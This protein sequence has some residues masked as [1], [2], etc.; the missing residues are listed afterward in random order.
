MDNNMKPVKNAAVP[1]QSETFVLRIST[2]NRYTPD[3]YVLLRAALLDWY[4]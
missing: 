4:R 1:R 2:A 3:W